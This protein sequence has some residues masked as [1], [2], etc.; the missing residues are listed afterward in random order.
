MEPPPRT[1]RRSFPIGLALS[2][3][4]LPGL[5]MAGLMMWA[6]WDHNAQGEIHNKDTGVDWA[7]WFLIGASWFAAVSV[8]PLLVV[9]ALWLGSRR[10]RHCHHGR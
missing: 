7:Y 9:T 4:L 8:I 5:I 2:L 3:S 6:A 10:S 1:A